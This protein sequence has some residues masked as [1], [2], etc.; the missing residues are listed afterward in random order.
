MAAV[1]LRG[2]VN[3]DSELILCD[4]IPREF[5]GKKVKLIL[6]PTGRPLPEDGSDPCAQMD[7]ELDTESKT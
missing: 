6:M 2:Y 5:R 4:P 7:S 1:E 3:Q